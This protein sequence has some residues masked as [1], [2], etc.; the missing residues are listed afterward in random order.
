MNAAKKKGNNSGTKGKIEPPP[1]PPPRPSL[2]HSI[3]IES[4]KE[5][6]PAPPLPP[7]TKQSGGTKYKTIKTKINEKN[8]N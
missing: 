7:A 3:P 4:L 6:P 1:I 8:T 5:P 2:Q